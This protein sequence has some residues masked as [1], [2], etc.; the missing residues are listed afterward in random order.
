ML[1]DEKRFE[2]M[3][4]ALLHEELPM[5]RAFSPPDGGMDGYDSDS[6]TIFQAYFPERAPRPDK[7]RGDL[8]KTR[9]NGWPC[10][11]WILLLPKN[12]PLSVANLVRKEQ[13]KWPFEIVVWGSTEIHALL[14]KHPAVQ[15]QYFRSEWKNELRK[16]AQGKGP[17]AGDAQPG[18]EII[19][20]ERE[21]IR[22][23]IEKLAEDEAKRKKRKVRDIDFKRE[24]GEFNV[25]FFLS[26][27]G[28]LPREKVGEARK[29]LSDKMYAR[30]ER[31]PVRLK[32]NRIVRGIKV[33]A[34]S[35]GMGDAP[36]RALLFEL[37]G[38]RSTTAM[39][40][41][42]LQRAFERF[43]QMQGL[44]ESSR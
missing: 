26:S 34:K 38:K 5:F 20:E 19:A 36:Y 7:I 37:T 43:K 11:R 28:R 12:P 8:E 21:E 31:E 33:I 3:C 15:E 39:D 10:K 13:S 18:L 30:R 16:I 23:M 22:E 14:R 9:T 4:Q 24:Y 17:R 27:Y 29:Y 25:N 42:E 2:E 44:R 35:L 41:K 6:E 32:R 40:M 1:L